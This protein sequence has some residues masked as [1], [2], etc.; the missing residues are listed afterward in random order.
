M[1]LCVDCQ[2]YRNLR[3]KATGGG[4]E[5]SREEFVRWKRESPQ[6]RRCVYC[7]IDG[8]QLYALGV[9]NI[10]TKKRYEVIG[11]D[12]RDN[13]LPYRPDNIQPCCGI[14]NGIKSGTLTHEEMIVLGSTLR[15]LWDAR[16]ANQRA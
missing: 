2:H 7:G 14:C 16:L 12:R 5:F 4:I 15:E 10:R 9:F 1:R 6:R 11:V 13:E 3:Q 8:E